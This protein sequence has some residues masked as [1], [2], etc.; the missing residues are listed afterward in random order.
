MPRDDVRELYTRCAKT[1]VAVG[2][3]ASET[4][5][6]TGMRLELIAGENPLTLTPG[7]TIDFTLLWE[8]QPLAGAQVALF[9]RGADGAL[10]SR[11]LARTD[12]DGKTSF[13]LPAPGTYMAAS[14]H[15]IEAA[16][17]RN[18]DWHSFWASLTF[19]VE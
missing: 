10:A 4:D 8:G 19:G 17:D 11:T 2:D 13:P 12:A 1:L 14:V 16:A 5:R 9:R 3:D 7:A 6:A 15:M 18:A